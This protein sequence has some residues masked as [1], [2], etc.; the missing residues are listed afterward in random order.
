[1]EKENFKHLLVSYVDEILK[2]HQNDPF[3]SDKDRQDKDKHEFT[4]E[5]GKRFAK[6]LHKTYGST[7]VH[8]FVEITTGDIY[9]A[10]TFRAHAKGVRGN[11]QNFRKPLFCAD[12]YKVRG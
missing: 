7:S 1:M 10:A 11:I 8:C 3:W 4:I 12:Y 9:K 2:A 5:Y 6:V